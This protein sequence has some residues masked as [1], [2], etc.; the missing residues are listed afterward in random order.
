MDFRPNDLSAISVIQK[1]FVF[2]IDTPILSP[3][4]TINAALVGLFYSQS[5]DSQAVIAAPSVK[6]LIGPP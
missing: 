3:I 4:G 2:V 1:I 5:G 6:H